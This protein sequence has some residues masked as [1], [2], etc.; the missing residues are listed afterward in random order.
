MKAA[1]KID[2]SSRKTELK[3]KDPYGWWFSDNIERWWKSSAQWGH[4]YAERRYNK[5]TKKAFL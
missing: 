5:V 3:F 4:D 2:Y 1:P